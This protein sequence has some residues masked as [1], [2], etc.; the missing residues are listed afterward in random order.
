M[1][2]K[3]KKI[4]EL[5]F[6]IILG[7]GAFAI[8]WN[9]LPDRLAVETF[10][11]INGLRVIIDPGHGGIDGGAQGNNIS[12]APL[13]L[14][15]ARKLRKELLAKGATISMT[16]SG[17]G[18][19]GKTKKE[20]MQK[21]KEI[22]GKNYDC[23]VSIHINKHTTSSPK[24]AVVFYQKNDELSE[25]LADSIQKQLNIALETF[26]QQGPKEGDYFILRY[27]ASP[28]VIVECGFISNS[29]DARLLQDSDHQAKLAK[30]IAQGVEDWDQKKIKQ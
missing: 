4:A 6:T 12:E 10:G 14:E 3:L 30:A 1:R 28:A 7:I 9:V 8:V 24:G 26:Q 18:A 19:I 21:R 15:I 11:T 23:V 5:F 16:R 2:D 22:I 13:N 17:E 27:A 29:E 25:L 20:D